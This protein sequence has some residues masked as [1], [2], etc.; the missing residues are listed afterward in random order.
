MFSFFRSTLVRNLFKNL[1]IVLRNLYPDEIIAAGS[2]NGFKK[3]NLPHQS[4]HQK[5]SFDEAIAAVMVE[6]GGTI[7]P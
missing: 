3:V 1:Q 5:R 2:T 6:M 4:L 7:I